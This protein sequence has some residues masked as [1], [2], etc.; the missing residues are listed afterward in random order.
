MTANRRPIQLCGTLS[1]AMV[2]AVAAALTGCSGMAAAAS[3]PSAQA[4]PAFPG[5]MGWAAHTP[6]G[7]GGRI[8]RVTTLAATGPGSFVEALEM[9]VLYARSWSFGRD[10]MLLLQTPVQVFRPKATR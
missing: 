9:D 7:R 5:A 10:I 8:I 2:M 1:V 3:S 6:G 4:V